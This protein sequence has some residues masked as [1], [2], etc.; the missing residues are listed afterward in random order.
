MLIEISSPVRDLA[1]HIPNNVEIDV[2]S[3]LNSVNEELCKLLT[4]EGIFL[5]LMKSFQYQ[6]RK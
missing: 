1:L 2:P 4:N 5:S 3:C 6:V